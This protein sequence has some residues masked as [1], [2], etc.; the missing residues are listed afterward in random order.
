MSSA[1]TKSPSSTFWHP[2][3]AGPNHHPDSDDNTI[4]VQAVRRWCFEVVDGESSA[5]V[6][7]SNRGGAPDALPLNFLL[8]CRNEIVTLCDTPAM[9]SNIRWCSVVGPDDC[10]VLF[11]IRR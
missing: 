5:C 2:K 1:R 4:A 6:S 8:T 7:E 3:P 11:V 9:S 10:A